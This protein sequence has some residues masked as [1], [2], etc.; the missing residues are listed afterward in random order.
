MA[1]S[2]TITVTDQQA[3]RFRT[4]LGA[5]LGLPGMANAAQC[6]DWIKARCKELTID[7]ETT[8]DAETNR[9]TKSAENW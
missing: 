1:V 7:T 2:L 4:S 6:Q 8:A 3:T 9:V 5:R